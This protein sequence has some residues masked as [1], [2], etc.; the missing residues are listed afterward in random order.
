MS[1]LQYDK[2]RSDSIASKHLRA[3]IQLWNRSVTQRDV[4]WRNRQE[5]QQKTSRGEKEK[6]KVIGDEIIN[7]MKV[8]Q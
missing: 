8:K 4:P 5:Q 2:L 7:R 6:K 1:R 3:S